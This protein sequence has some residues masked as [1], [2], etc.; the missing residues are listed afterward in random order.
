MASSVGWRVMMNTLRT[1]WETASFAWSSRCGRLAVLGILNLFICHFKLWFSETFLP[2]SYMYPSYPRVMQ[3]TGTRRP[4]CIITGATTGLG[5]AAVFALCREGFYVVLVGRSE[6]LL[7][8]TMVEL[9]QKDLDAHVKAFQVDLLSFE[10]ML[11]FKSS[12]QQWLLDSDMHPSIQLLI[13]NAGI[14]A[15]SQRFT[16]EGYDETS[17]VVQSWQVFS[18]QVNKET[19]IASSLPTAY[20]C[21]HVYES[22]KL[23]LVL[24]SYELHRQLRSVESST[25]LS[26]VVTDPG[27]AETKIMREFSWHVKSVVFTVLKCCGFLQSPEDGA[28]CIID[29]ALAPPVSLACIVHLLSIVESPLVIVVVV[30]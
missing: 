4:V 12:L 30:V 14:L 8:Q 25:Q 28:I 10:S 24:F 13:N 7:S 22:S 1:C 21:G 11:K 2:K 19:L 29:A 3:N 26:V 16:S 18:I 15:T 23:F 5:K 6:D 17:Y 9:K 20:P 27:A